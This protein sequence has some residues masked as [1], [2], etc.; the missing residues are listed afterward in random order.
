MSRLFDEDKSNLQAKF[1][2]QKIAFAPLMFQAARVLRDSGILDIIKKHRRTGLTPEE[3]AEKSGV[4]LYGVKVLT[5]AG[6]AMDLLRLE[7]DRFYI[8]KTGF[9]VLTDRM[10]RVN[11]DFAHDV[12]YK[13]MF[14]LDRAIAEARPAGLGEFGDWET[15]YQA[16]SSL[17]PKAQESW[18]AFDHYYSDD[19]FPAALPLVFK[20]KPKKLMDIGGNT[21]KW[22]FQCTDFNPDVSV[23]ILDLP[24]QLAMAQKNIRERGREGRIGTHAINILDPSQAFPRGHDAIW[25][26]QFLDCFSETEIISILKRAHE[27]MDENAVLF[28]M[29][30]YWDRQSYEAA[31]YCVIGTSLYFTAMANGNSKMYHSKDMI[32]CLREAGLVV[33]D[34]VDNVGISH[35]LFACKK[36]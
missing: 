4:S 9:F 20:R 16:L 14:H 19:A 12:C 11:M 1:D 5:E 6:L 25:M 34:D 10:T 21:G 3:I 7:D 2:A 27:A 28:I 17:P 32:K 15:I 33:E 22:A 18:F 30:T 23:T 31:R 13:G 29:E 24:G 36:R 8:T 26:S 35:T